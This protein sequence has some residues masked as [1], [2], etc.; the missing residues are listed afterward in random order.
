M[1]SYIKQSVAILYIEYVVIWQ[2]KYLGS[3]LV[4]LMYMGES[5]NHTY[6]SEKAGWFTNES[7][8]FMLIASALIVS[9]G[10]GP[11]VADNFCWL[12]RDG[13]KKYV[14]NFGTT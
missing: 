8:D 2:I 6:T 10:I 9:N 4:E 5:Q 14:R 12:K 11:R 7:S 1:N 3:E 13:Q